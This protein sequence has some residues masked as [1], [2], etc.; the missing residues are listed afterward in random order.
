LSSQS[1]R[2]STRLLASIFPTFE[3]GG[4][5]SRFVTL[6]NHF[7]RDLKHVV[8]AMDGHYDCAERLAPGLDVELRRYPL[9][10]GRTFANRALFRRALQE[11]RPDVLVT[12]NWGTIEW[13]M[14]NWPKRVRH[15]HIED[16][17]GPDEA[18]GQLPR[19]VWTRRLVL[20]RS[21]V[22][23]P[24]RMLEKIAREIWRLPNDS[25]HYIPNG[26]DCAR[27][28]ARAMRVARLRSP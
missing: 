20:R 9:Q 27:F 4:A 10:K 18:G 19:R 8:V 17:F 3:V 6:A 5:Q 2:G 1:R 28:A 25:V 12:H 24:S 7:G 15:I 21:T 14:A 13:A 16:G 26:I 11:I 23:V 22:V